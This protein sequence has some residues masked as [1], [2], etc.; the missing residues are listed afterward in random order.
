MKPSPRETQLREMREAAFRFNDRAR[1]VLD[2]A[3]DV[4]PVE[5]GHVTKKVVTEKDLVTEKRRG[6]PKKPGGAMTG[7]ERIRRMREK[8]KGK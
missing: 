4:P 1:A 3:E 7:A 2:R 8:R 5:A 6:R